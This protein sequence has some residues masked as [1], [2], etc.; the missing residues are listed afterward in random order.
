M[1]KETMEAIETAIREHVRAL[2]DE[3]SPVLDSWVIAW[4]S[5]HVVNADDGSMRICHVRDYSASDTSPMTALGLATWLSM[6]I[7]DIDENSE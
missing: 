4:E 5:S 7:V 6:A 2:S 1:S 3:E